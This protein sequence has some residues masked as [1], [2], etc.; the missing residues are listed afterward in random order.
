V[1]KFRRAAVLIPPKEGF[2]DFEIV[3]VLEL[4]EPLFSLFLEYLERL[5]RLPCG[6]R[7]NSG[8]EFC[9]SLA[10]RK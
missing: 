9:R 5:V 7:K 2:F 6:S 8:C 4:T 10:P 1:L 3:K